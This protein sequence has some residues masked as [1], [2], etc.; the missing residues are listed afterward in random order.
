MQRKVVELMIDLVNSKSCYSVVV[1]VVVVV[2]YWIKKAEV[3]E[4][5]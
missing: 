4:E 3:Q 2:A 1:V 5:Q